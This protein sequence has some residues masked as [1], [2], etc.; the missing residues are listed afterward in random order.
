MAEDLHRGIVIAS[1]CRTAVLG[2]LAG[3]VS[4]HKMGTGACSASYGAE[5]TAGDVKNSR[6]GHWV[7]AW[8]KMEGGFTAWPPSRC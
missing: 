3:E 4:R 2:V 7:W 1:C 6:F 5:R 8:T